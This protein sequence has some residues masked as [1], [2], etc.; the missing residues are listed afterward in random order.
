LVQVL[1]DVR[2]RGGLSRLFAEHRPQIV[3]H[4]AAFKHVPILEGHADEA[5]KTN[6]VGTEHVMAAGREV[7]VERFVL[8]S[9]DK[10]VHPINAMGA[11]KRMAEMLVQAAAQRRDGCNYTAVR[12]GNVLG[13]RGSVIP[14]F[15][16][17]IAAGGPVT[18]TDP[19]MTRYFMT[20]DE[21]VQLVLQAAALA[22]GGEILMLDMGE[23][24][25]IID[26]A[27][28]LIR[29]AGLVPGRDIEIQIT[30]R[31]PGEKLVEQLSSEPLGVTDHPQIM[32]AFPSHPEPVTTR[33]SLDDLTRLAIEGDRAGTRRLLMEVTSTAWSTEETVDLRD[34]RAATSTPQ[35]AAPLSAMGPDSG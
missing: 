19:G 10:A 30:G 11:S 35:P 23:P 8:I 15:I 12:F 34:P 17:Q 9:S 18:V 7:G 5:V 25:L 16:S 22:H 3:F 28:R 6:V 2:D 21:S 31:R 20:V 14:T 1:G 33:E 13:S 32:V 24:V 29:L 4:A 27:H 26:L